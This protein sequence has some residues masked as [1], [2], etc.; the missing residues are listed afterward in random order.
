MYLTIQNVICLVFQQKK[1]NG[2][3]KAVD[4][5]KK[6]RKPWRESIGINKQQ[7]KS[8]VIMVTAHIIFKLRVETAAVLYICSVPIIY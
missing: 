4:D 5:F 3:K 6:R 1:S 7:L 8:T 2:G